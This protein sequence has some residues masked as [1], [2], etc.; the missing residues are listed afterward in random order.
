MTVLDSWVQSDDVDDNN[1]TELTLEK[2]SLGE[3][4]ARRAREFH[5]C[6]GK[7]QVVEIMPTQSHSTY[8]GTRFAMF[9]MGYT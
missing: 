1:N 4:S 2:L 8:N 6:S 9:S 7:R 5:S 3:E